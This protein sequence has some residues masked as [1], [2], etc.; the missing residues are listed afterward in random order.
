M[1]DY[2]PLNQG[3]EWIW[4]K[5]VDSLPE[6]F[7]DGDINLGEPFVDVN[8]N[9]IYDPG[10]E[11][12]DLNSNGKYDGP[13]DPWTPGIPYVDRNNDGEYDPPN[14]KW[15]E[16]EPFVDLDSNDARNWPQ[17]DHLVRLKGTTS[18]VLYISED[19]SKVSV[20]SLSWIG[21]VGVF[22]RRYNDYG[23]S[24][25]SRGFRWHTHTTGWVFAPEDDLKDHGPITIA[26]ATIQIGDSVIN[27]D[28][29]DTSG[30][31]YMWISVFEGVE[32]VT[33]PAGDF[34]DCLKFR[35]IAS[36]WT[37]NMQKFNGTSYQWYAKGVGLVK[38]EGP[39]ENEYWILESARINGTDYP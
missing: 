8:H 15:E 20:V 23:F 25:D 12:E 30:V 36:G 13:G 6:P 2:F 39:G 14:G 37:G 11:Y 26:P 18:G 33:V 16:G 34:Q 19:G 27:A 3:D 38:L 31:I 9:G 17:V 10:E 35:S 32:N 5:K 28:T 4:E 1:K 21:G 29:C 24:N 7:V 22:V